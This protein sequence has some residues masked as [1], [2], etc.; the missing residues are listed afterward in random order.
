MS[1]LPV[2]LPYYKPIVTEDYANYKTYTLYAAFTVADEYDIDGYYAPIDEEVLQYAD[3]GDFKIFVN[4]KSLQNTTLKPSSGKTH[5][6]S[7]NIKATLIACD[8]E[9]KEIYNNSPFAFSIS[10]TIDGEYNIKTASIDDKN[11]IMKAVVTEALTNI[12]KGF[13]EKFLVNTHITDRYL[14]MA[15]LWALS[16]KGDALEMCEQIH[17]FENLTNPSDVRALAKE[18]IPF[19]EKFTTLSNSK[20]E[21]NKLY[22]GLFNSAVMYYLINDLE[23]SQEYIDKINSTF[24]KLGSIEKHLLKTFNEFKGYYIPEKFMLPDVSEMNPIHPEDMQSTASMDSIVESSLYYAIDN[25]EITMKNGSVVNGK[26]LISRTLPPPSMGG[27]IVDL[28][29]ANYPIKIA[30]NSGK[31]E[32]NKLSEVVSVKSGDDHYKCL[33]DAVYKAEYLGEKASL[34]KEVFPSDQEYKYLKAGE[35]KLVSPSILG[36]NK[37]LQKFFKDCPELADKIKNKQTSLFPLDLIK[38]YNEECK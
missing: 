19:W 37:W 21:K 18:Q 38:Y 2:K 11:K 9:G 34:Y 5:I 22:C 6:T 23:K 17:K 31:E 15:D 36:P 10:T 32:K 28:S 25:A 12:I 16:L 24:E 4:I 26:L 30:D 29:K 35:N 3:N 1:Q 14:Y 27:Q 13:Q 8:K 20:E 33:S 7:D